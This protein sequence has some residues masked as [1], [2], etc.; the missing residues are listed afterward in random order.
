MGI[1]YSK[2]QPIRSKNISLYTNLLVKETFTDLKQGH[3]YK[4]TFGNEKYEKYE[5]EG[6]F[7]NYIDIF[8]K[9][10][11]YHYECEAMFYTYNKKWRSLHSNK[12]FQYYR[13]VSTKEYV[14]KR[15]DKFNE[16]VL[17]TV[18]NRLV[19]EEFEWY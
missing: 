19:N 14:K 9:E 18:L 1:I 13:F 16:N 5:Y 4:F 10:S 7:W 15:R 17:K 11:D 3:K 12:Y 8:G 2:Y 6:I